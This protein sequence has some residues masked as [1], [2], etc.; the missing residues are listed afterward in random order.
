VNCRGNHPESN[1]ADYS[2]DSAVNGLE[3]HL[4]D[5]QTDSLEHNLPQSLADNLDRC[6]ENHAVDY[7][8]DSPENHLERNLE[9]NW[10]DNLPNYSA[11]YLAIRL[12]D[13]LENYRPSAVFIPLSAARTISLRGR[14][15]LGIWVCDFRAVIAALRPRRVPNRGRRFS[16]HW[17]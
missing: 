6:L 8:A 7:S 1:S 11:D 2:P 15:C 4:D 9:G 10:A 3:H 12:P 5:Y 13:Y 16:S 17:P 14:M